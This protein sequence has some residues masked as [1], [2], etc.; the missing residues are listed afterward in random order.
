MASGFSRRF[1]PENKLLVPFRGKPLARHTLDLVLGMDC[2]AGIFFVAACNEVAALARNGA[3]GDPQRAPR[4]GPAG[5][6]PAWGSGRIGRQR[7]VRR[8]G[9]R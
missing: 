4:T 3:A 1:A 6:H 2:F 7:P 8:R 9:F 5:K